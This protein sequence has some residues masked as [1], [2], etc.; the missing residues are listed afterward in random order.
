MF[1]PYQIQT[2]FK[3][4]NT[5]FR[6]GYLYAILFPEY[7]LLVKPM[8]DVHCALPIPLRIHPIKMK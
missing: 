2:A 8:E 5:E 7:V 6:F 1:A 4:E 3:K